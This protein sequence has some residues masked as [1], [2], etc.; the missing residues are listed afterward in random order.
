[1]VWLAA[2][3]QVFAA[4]C[5]ARQP[6]R[7]AP[8]TAPSDASLDAAPATERAQRPTVCIDEAHTN[9]HTRT[10]RYAPFADALTQ[11]GFEVVGSTQPFSGDV[12]A[13]CDVLVVSNALHPSNET[14]WRV[15]IRPAF[16]DGEPAAVRAFVESGGGLLLIADHMPFPAAAAPLAGAFGVTFS[17]GFA[18][19]PTGS[20]PDSFSREAGTLGEHEVTRGVEVVASFT[21]QAFRAPK[22][23]TSLLTFPAGYVS[24]EPAEAWLFD[25]N[26]PRHDVGG[27]SQGLVL[28]VGEG[29]VAIWG[30]AAMFTTQEVDGGIVGIGAPEAKDNARLRENLVRWL[31]H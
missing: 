29:R 31:A 9:F 27:W 17:N 10:G 4:G 14:T 15:P 5:V 28:E 30:E 22:D 19:S 18:M 7:S 13:R 20:S 26:T 6:D 24:L 21:G 1:M 3:C 16:A 8:S 23:A 25:D 2:S 11:A 12:L